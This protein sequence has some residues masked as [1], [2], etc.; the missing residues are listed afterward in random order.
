MNT[1]EIVE[2][3]IAEPGRAPTYVAR[4]TKYDSNPH[5]KLL[6]PGLRANAAYVNPIENGGLHMLSRRQQTEQEINFS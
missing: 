2:E 3:L 1:H 4:N 5:N 6:K